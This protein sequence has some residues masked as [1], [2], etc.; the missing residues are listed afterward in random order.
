MV[1]SQKIKFQILHVSEEGSTCDILYHP[2]GDTILTCGP[3]TQI[4]VTSVSDRKELGH[5]ETQE[6]AILSL[7]T[8]RSGD[9][10]LSC[11]E[12]HS[13]HLLKYTDISNLEKL[14]T[15]F[16]SPARHAV[17][18]AN[19]SFVAAAGD[20][21]TIKVILLMSTNQVE[22]LKGHSGPVRS[23]AYDPRDIYLAS[24]GS[25][26]TLRLW[27]TTKET[28]R[29]VTCLNVVSKDRHN[30]Q[31]NRIAW[32]PSGS[33][34]AVP[35]GND[36]RVLDRDTWKISYILK[37]GHSKPVSLISWSPNGNYLA[38]SGL[39]NQVLI[40]NISTKESL[41]SYKHDSFISGLSWSP[42]T[43]A[44]AMIDV[45]GQ[46]GIWENPIPTKFPNPFSISNLKIQKTETDFNSLFN[47]NDDMDD[48]DDVEGKPSEVPVVADLDAIDGLSDDEIVYEK[49]SKKIQRKFPDQAPAVAVDISENLQPPFQPSSTQGQR[50]K[51]FLCFNKLGSITLKEET[52]HVNIQV[53]YHNS[54]KNRPMKLTDRNGTTMGVLGNKGVALGAPMGE[55]DV[56]STITFHPSEAWGTNSSWTHSLPMGEQV[57]A[58]AVCDQYVVA[59]TSMKFLR[60]FTFTGVQ[61][62]VMSYSGKIVCMAGHLSFLG[63]VL[64]KSNPIR[65]DQNLTML[66]FNLKTRQ[67]VLSEDLPITS[68]S[69][70]TWFGFSTSGYP[71]S[72]D[73]E[74]IVQMFNSEWN[75]WTPILNFK[76][77]FSNPGEKFWIFGISEKFA[78]VILIKNGDDEP[79]IFPKPVPG[80]VPLKMPLLNL[81]SETTQLEESYIRERL[82]YHNKKDAV[83][84]DDED[85][86]TALRRE[87]VM[88]DT[89]VM[90]I[91]EQAIRGDKLERALDVADMIQFEKPLQRV[92]NL[93]DQ[94]RHTVLVSR[95]EQ[96]WK[97]KF[98]EVEDQVEDEEEQVEEAAP[99]PAKISK[100][101]PGVQV[102]D[103]VQVEEEIQVENQVENQVEDVMED[104][105]EKKENVE[106]SNDEKPKNRKRNKFAKSEEPAKFQGNSETVFDALK[107]I[108][109]APERPIKVAST[110]KEV[111]EKT[112]KVDTPTKRK[113]TS[114]F[115]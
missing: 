59:A 55:N 64:H 48:L 57:L 86:M 112:K 39:D 25:D 63:I 38:S 27:E 17:F 56:P 98:G 3:D 110:T 88:L 34:L 4:K 97:S 80:T 65:G 111:V 11:S 67:R 109:K 113:L 61:Y 20:D 54:T 101:E 26:G 76:N 95:L 51:R 103:R 73:S 52:T 60:I 21:G 36:I 42:K 29:E 49:K 106:P 100:K 69:V 6:G 82:Y 5:A 22:I 44:I 8:T 16:Q 18:S 96:L 10:I 1:Q 37:D 115:Q 31:F 105:E 66:T 13:V 40:W 58:L 32:H 85:A 35:F 84:E 28:I 74:G 46:Y 72:C 102:E 99:P 7:A 2:S 33:W 91:A 45:C 83:D 114:Y 108:S 14:I 90:Q 104:E 24:A 12:D 87:A 78:N 81:E 41:H 92:M 62:H 70:L 94:M 15:R 89:L 77:Q 68:G 9:R 19:E 79:S 71:T 23:L 43:N 75:T 50:G 47:D 30:Y 107:E 53:D 93:A